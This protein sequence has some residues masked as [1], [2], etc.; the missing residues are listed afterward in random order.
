MAVLTFPKSK[1]FNVAIVGGG[2]G[3]LAFAIGLSRHP[4]VSF[5]I[6][7]AAAQ[8]SEI[9]AGVGFG[10]NSQ[11]AMKLIDPAIWEGYS[12]RATYNG[13]KSKA[14]S[15]FDFTVGEKGPEEGKRIIEVL[16]HNDMTVSTVH[17]AHFLD[18][19]IRL[20]P[21]G[22]ARYGKRL[23]SI[24]QSGEKV[25]VKFADGSSALADAVIGCDG[26]RSV[27]RGVVLGQDGPFTQPV[28]TGKVCYRGLV[29]MENA[30]RAVGEERARNRQMYLGH[31]GHVITFPVGNGKI[32]NVAA[33]STKKDDGWEGPWVQRNQ[34]ENM[35]KSYEGWGEVVMK[36]LSV[37]CDNSEAT[38]PKCLWNE[39]LTNTN[40]LSS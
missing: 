26:V 35:F 14:G 40:F 19:L 22:S 2:I 9:G 34:K 17:R 30:V 15:W 32:M 33:F 36:I 3:G 23:V 10:A 7:E 4:H 11:A 13:W 28:F 18:E 5:T 20:V 38:I 25:E 39:S 21:E 16:F 24:D 37:G 1:P 29:P 6:Y 27:C 12:K 31:G 8:F